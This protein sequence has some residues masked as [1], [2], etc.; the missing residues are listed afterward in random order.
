MN[1]LSTAKKILIWAGT[2]ILLCLASARANGLFQQEQ[3]A[4][5]FGKLS[6]SC[7]LAGV[8]LA[9]IGGLSYMASEGFYDIL[10]YGVKTVWT[11]FRTGKPPVGFAEYKEKKA[12]ERRPWRKEA[13]FTGLV[14]LLLS[15]IFLIL[16]HNM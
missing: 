2:G 11:L 13:F 14:F 16:Y 4:E 12:A 5:V 10:S 8:I 9:G 6:D 7:F 15:V 1:G 3:T